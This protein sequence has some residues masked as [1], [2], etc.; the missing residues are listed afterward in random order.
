MFASEERQLVFK[1]EVHAAQFRMQ[2][3]LGFSTDLAAVSVTVEVV[4][5]MLFKDVSKW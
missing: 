4:V 1:L 3:V 2:M 5:V